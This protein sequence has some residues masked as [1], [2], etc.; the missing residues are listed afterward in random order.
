M[1]YTAITVKGQVVIPASIR[2]RLNIKKGT[3]FCVVESEGKI[4]FQ[5]MTKDYFRRVAGMLKT[6][7]ALTRDLLDERKAEKG[8]EDSK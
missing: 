3:R 1:T 6:N 5:P 7:G 4:I 2:K 8:R